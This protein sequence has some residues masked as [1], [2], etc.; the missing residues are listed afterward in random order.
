MDSKRIG[1]IDAMRGLTMVLVVY[2]HVCSYCLGNPSA[3]F[4]GVLFLFRLPCFFFISGWLFFKPDRV[5]DCPTVRQVVAR[6]FMVQIVP[7]AIFLVLLVV[8]HDGQPPAVVFSRLGATKGGYWFTFALFEFF[9]LY[10]LTVLPFRRRP[11]D[12]M[13]F[14][15]ALTISVAAFCYDAYYHRLLSLSLPSPT[16]SAFPTL[17]P[18]LFRILGFLSFM[19][20]RYYLFFYIGIWV[21][22]HFDTFVAWT[23]KTAVIAVLCGTFAAVAL[24]PRS[25]SVVREYMA[26]ALGGV[27]GM[28]LVFTLFRRLSPH[29]PHFPPLSFLGRR[30]LDVYLLHYFFLPRFLLPYGQRLCGHGSVLS[31]SVAAVLLS[32]LVTAVCLLVSA[33]IR[34]SPFL[35]HYLFGANYEKRP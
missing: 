1:Y 8:L 15:A 12:G 27:S 20:W 18:A 30:T 13:Q 2:S 34:L 33:I 23:D 4:N 19:T 17:H 28:T 22:R 24:M 6:K 7:T 5:W 10:I 25:G 31:E 11:N 32:L 26:F 29:I 9:I 21:R 3:G 14:L 35:G 16:P